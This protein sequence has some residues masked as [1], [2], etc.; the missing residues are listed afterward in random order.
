MDLFLL[1]LKIVL[2]SLSVGLML[3]WIPVM[4]WQI[5]IGLRG[6]FSRKAPVKKEDKKYSFAVL[7]CARN[8][9]KVIGNLIDSIR[10]QDYDPSLYRIFCVA[11]N[12]TDAT[13]QV[14]REHGAEVLERFDE[15]NRGKRFALELATAYVHNQYPDRFDAFLVFDADNL[16]APDFMQKISDGLC[17][18]QDIVTGFRDTKNPFDSWVSGCYDIYWTLVMQLFNGVRYSWGLSSLVH[19]TGFAVRAELLKDGWNTTTITEDGEFSIM[20]RL[21][22]RK[23]ALIPDAHFYDE[24]PTR[25]KYFFAQFHRWEVGGMQCARKLLGQAFRRI[26]QDPA[27]SLDCISFLLLPTAQTAM[28]LNLIPYGALL[29][30]AGLPVKLLWVML[31]VTV[32]MT[33]CVIAL[34]LISLLRAGKPA[35]RMWRSVVL[36]PIFVLPMSVIATIAFFRPKTEW[37][38]IPHESKINMETVGEVPSDPLV[39]QMKKMADNPIV[40]KMK[41]AVDKIRTE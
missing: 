2:V 41:K 12:C 22:G 35:G 16:L 21:K 10:A 4:G 39:D 1:I 14:A 36:F 20:Q 8:E 23:I 29:F 6:F 17:S 32:L 11:D 31:G 30:L 24:Q 3:C 33:L 38:T 18:G 13:A 19:G 28:C 15:K 9:E 26:P 5:V 40:D 37:K 34:G 27:D 7:I 25:V